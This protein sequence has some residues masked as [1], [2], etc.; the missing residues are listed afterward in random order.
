MK[1]FKTI[2][3]ETYFP[4]TTP[5]VKSSFTPTE[6]KDFQVTF[7]PILVEDFNLMGPVEASEIGSFEPLFET[8]E[9]RFMVK[10]SKE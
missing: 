3:E 6:K 9:G 7:K 4:K 10:M 8:L 5:F 1:S 2:Y